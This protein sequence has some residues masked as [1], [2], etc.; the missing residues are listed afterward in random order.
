M[1]K[2]LLLDI[3]FVAQTR[4]CVHYTLTPMS[5]IVESGRHGVD[6]D[7]PAFPASMGEDAMRTQTNAK[8]RPERHLLN[9][10]RILLALLAGPMIT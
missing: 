10:M 6:A 3:R 5:A 8:S 2:R 4:L 7:L 1:T 9:I